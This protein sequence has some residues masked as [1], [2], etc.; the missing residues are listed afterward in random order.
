MLDRI[1]DIWGQR[2]PYADSE[3]PSRLDEHVVEEPERWIQSACVLCSHGC[4]LDI[5][6][7]SGRMVA[8]R[9]RVIDRVNRGRLGPKGLHGWVANHSSDRLTRPLVRRDGRLIETTWDE[10]LAEVVARS[11]DV[12]AKYGSGA[13]GFYCSGQMMLE[14]YYALAQIARAV[15]YLGAFWLS[16]WE[17][18]GRPAPP[19]GQY[20]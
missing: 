15:E 3:W 9:G 8:V 14:E 10:A 4:S 1:H 19:G 16:A 7:K 11:K 20:Q 18:A 2:A 5:G 13:I 17:Q 6:V 12:G